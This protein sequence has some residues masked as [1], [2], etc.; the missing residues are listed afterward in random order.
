MKND[1]FC[2]ALLIFLSGRWWRESHCSSYNIGTSTW[3]FLKEHNIYRSEP[4]FRGMKI[5]YL[6][7]SQVKWCPPLETALY[8]ESVCA[9]EAGGAHCLRH[10]E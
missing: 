2:F 8:L 10:G 1:L 5:N 9:M 7:G 3:E 4:T 6:V